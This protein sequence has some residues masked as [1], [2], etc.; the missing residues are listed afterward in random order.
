M[1]Y[2]PMWAEQGISQPFFNI[3]STNIDAFISPLQELEEPLLVKVDVLGPY[4]CFSIFIG[5]E[6]ATFEC[7]LQ[8]RE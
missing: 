7:P 4:G 5:G 2:T 1:R 8:S 3:I 6:T